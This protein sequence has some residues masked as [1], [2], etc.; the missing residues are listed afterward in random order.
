[1]RS[2]I[3]KKPIRCAMAL[4]L[5]AAILT[6][7]LPVRQVFMGGGGEMA[8]TSCGGLKGGDEGIGPVLEEYGVTPEQMDEW[9][10]DPSQHCWLGIPRNWP[11]R[12]YVMSLEA[13]PGLL[14]G[15]MVDHRSRLKY[16]RAISLG[17]VWGV[18]VCHLLWQRMA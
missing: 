17:I 5:V 15:R 14:F 13:A 1:M 4:V 16:D 8:G 9:G 10:V 18:A 11:C 3:R 12:W 7:L 6:Y 2:S